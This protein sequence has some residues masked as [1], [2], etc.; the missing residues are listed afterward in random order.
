MSAAQFEELL[1]NQVREKPCFYD[2]R[3][4]DYKRPDVKDNNW[5]EIAIALNTDCE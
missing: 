4:V 1:I 2:C 5:K 3:H